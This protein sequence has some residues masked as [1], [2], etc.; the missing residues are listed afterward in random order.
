MMGNFREV[1]TVKSTQSTLEQ[2][3]S[4]SSSDFP[5]VALTCFSLMPLLGQL[6]V[7]RALLHCS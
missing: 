7:L 3:Q 4:V 1:L 5:D 6:D 2:L